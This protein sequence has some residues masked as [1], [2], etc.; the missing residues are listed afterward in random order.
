MT[1]YA[2]MILIIYL[3]F[4]VVARKECRVPVCQSQIGALHELI[5]VTHH[6]VASLENKLGAY[7]SDALMSHSDAL[8]VVNNQLSQ[9][10]SDAVAQSIK[11]SDIPY[12]IN[13]SGLYHL[14]ESITLNSNQTAITIEADNVVL[15]MQGLSITGSDQPGVNA[16]ISVINSKNVGI[17]NG[18][19]QNIDGSAIVVRNSAHILLENFLTIANHG[20]G[21]M[22]D[23]VSSVRMAICSAAQNQGHGIFVQSGKVVQCDRTYALNNML[24]GFNVAA[25]NATYTGCFGVENSGSGFMHM[26]NG[27]SS[28]SCKAYRNG[29]HG[30][31]CSTST[32]IHMRDY[33]AHNNFSKGLQLSSSSEFR[34]EQSMISSNSS[35]GIGIQDCQ[36][37]SLV[38][39]LIQKN[40]Q[41]G[42]YGSG[43]DRIVIIQSDLH[44]NLSDGLHVAN[45]LYWM[46][47]KNNVQHNGASGIRFLGM[48]SSIEGNRSAH[49][50]L[51]SI[52]QYG[53]D[54]GLYGTTNELFGNRC[55]HNGASPGLP[56]G[57]DT[58]YSLGVSQSP[59]SSAIGA[60][61]FPGGGVGA[62]EN[63]TT[64]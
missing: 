49:N 57:T 55:K 52:D 56:I 25:D 21:F 8:T 11:A 17:F 30:L 47:K 10:P 54:I 53:I 6:K 22:F 59:I 2:A 36:N 7:H 50:G 42:V 64:T 61:V 60:Q 5:Q 23:T 16:A 12:T 32:N 15:D 33:M 45:G 43:S 20:H 31:H 35:D 13:E 63:I 38:G 40:Q 9:M 34:V 44:D 62:L 58:N 41:H 4:L 39:C 18:T 19:I 28:V 46:I 1:R 3:P 29:L 14:I 48:H 27:I 51:G 26:G 37:G 24:D